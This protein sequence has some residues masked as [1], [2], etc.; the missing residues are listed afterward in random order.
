MGTEMFWAVYP[1]GLRFPYHTFP[2]DCDVPESS[3]SFGGHST[4]EIEVLRSGWP[5]EARFLDLRRR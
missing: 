4:C 3:L 5:N 2:L 1:N